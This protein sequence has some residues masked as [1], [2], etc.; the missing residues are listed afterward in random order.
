M[1]G[2][3]LGE[4]FEAVPANSYEA[5]I[6]RAVERVVIDEL[7]ALA[8]GARMPQVR[9][10]ATMALEVTAETLGVAEGNA[11]AAELAHRRL[12]ARDIQRFLDQPAVP[13]ARPGTVTAP[14]GAPIGE[15][16]MEWIRRFMPMPE[17]PSIWFR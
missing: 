7:S 17:C 10:V 12:L 2:R 14:P 13:Y 1:I 15:P 16:A 3:L 4:T 6:A 11:D 8:A 5:E 9:A